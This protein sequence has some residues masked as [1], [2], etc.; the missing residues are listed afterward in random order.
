MGKAKI[1][2]G[3]CAS[4][5]EEPVVLK[6]VNY[7]T[8]PFQYCF[9]FTSTLLLPSVNCCSIFLIMVLRNL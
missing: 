9:S 2:S 1:L 4:K 5:F 3:D 8:N 6:M 7:V